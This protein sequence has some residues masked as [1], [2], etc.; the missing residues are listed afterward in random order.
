M[1]TLAERKALFARHIELQR[2][3]EREERH[4]RLLRDQE[5]FKALIRST[6]EITGTM[7]YREALELL[8]EQ[9]AFQALAEDDRIR[10]FDEVITDIWR[11]EAEARRQRKRRAAE[12]FTQLLNS[13][14]LTVETP[15][16]EAQVRWRGALASDPDY[17]EWGQLDQLTA[18]ETYIRDLEARE[19]E[20][21][22]Q[23]R[24]EQ[25]RRE[26]HARAAFGRLL[27]E[28]ERTGQVTAQTSWKQLYSILRHRT[29]Y[30]SLL[31]AQSGS[32]P[33]DLFWDRLDV[34]QDAYV[35]EMQPIIKKL[36]STLGNDYTRWG[37]EGDKELPA[38]LRS[39]LFPLA[40]ALSGSLAREAIRAKVEVYRRE[41]RRAIDQ[42]KHA[43]KH[44]TPPITLNTTYESIAEAMG[45]IPE[46][47]A[48]A[49]ED[50]RRYY[51]DK[52][53]RHLRKRAGLE[54]DK[55]D[56]DQ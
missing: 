20:A 19:E 22:E 2:E 53:I 41:Y 13:L 8:S 14:Q 12:K 16:Q 4:Q 6:P 33:L 27:G 35:Q 3:V 39:H 34:L 46:I 11:E 44:F 26:R 17:S 31:A 49:E 18:F 21:S 55:S 7:R 54:V 50:I 37:E 45:K 32:T 30:Q 24:K 28:L 40:P 25:R 51:F 1:P 43:I 38:S 29:E 36:Q 10:I 9:A 48:V 23:R 5:A 15:W 47:V 42:L 56:D 52:Y